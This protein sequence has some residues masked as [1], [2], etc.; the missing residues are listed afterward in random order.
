MNKWK[1][2]CNKVILF[3]IAPKEILYLCINLTKIVKDLYDENYVLLMKEI[4]EDINAKSWGSSRPDQLHHQQSTNTKKE[5][6]NHVA[7][8]LHIKRTHY[9]IE[10]FDPES[11]ILRYSLTK[12]LGLF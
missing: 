8:P 10:I 6:Q 4:K 1:T 7:L 3:T 12:L 11:P 5:R 2:K 9:V